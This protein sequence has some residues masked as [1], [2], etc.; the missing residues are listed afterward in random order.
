[1]SLELEDI[2]EKKHSKGMYVIVG[3]LLIGMA[4]FG[5]SQFGTGGG[6]SRQ[7]LLEAGNSVVTKRDYDDALRF[8]QG[9]N[10]NLTAEQSRAMALSMLRQRVALADYLN[11][12]Q[13]A[14]SNRQIDEVIT[15]TP[16]FFDN[17]KFSET[18]FR[19]KVPIAAEQ[20]RRGVSNDIA[21]REF[22]TVLAGSVVV[23]DAELQPYLDLVAMSRDILVAKIARNQFSATAD[24]DEIQAFYDKNKANFMTAEQWDIEYVDFNPE[25]IVAAEKVD[26]AVVAD[27]VVA[28]RHVAYLLFDDAD[29]AQAVYQASQSGKTWDTL[30][31]EFAAE[32]SDSGELGKV[33]KVAD[34]DSLVSQDALD[35]IFALA[36][37]GEMTAPIKTDDG[38]M[39]FTVTHIEK[40]DS[41]SQTAETAKLQ[42]Q[43]A[44]AAGKI[45]TLSEKLNKAVF[46]NASPTLESIS[47]ATELPVSHTGLVAAN[48]GQGILALPEVLEAINQSDKTLGKI[49]EPITVGE[50]VLIYRLKAI[51][52]SEQ[53]PLETVK[54]HVEQGIIAEKV[55]KQLAEASNALVEATKTD[56]LETAA[57]AKNYPVQAYENFNGNVGEGSVL[58]PVAAFL[59]AQQPPALDK[60][61]AQIVALPNG[62]SYVY[63]TT[64]VRLQSDDKAQAAEQAK[65]LKANL[66]NEIGGMELGNFLQTVTEQT[67]VT[68]RSQSVLSQ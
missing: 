65:Q 13:L 18:V 22:Q 60:Q 16:A 67:K 53:K 42:V 59:L 15:T 28:P 19:E 6:N 31:N 54:P 37:V 38:I 33:N 23:S 51:K 58:N 50:R 8:I 49:Q 11:R 66:N 9:N 55:E 14:A 35:R 4:G 1:M 27:H 17:G 44:Q 45:A 20:Y 5:T 3:L 7:A 56:G 40:P 25:A 24:A 41:N 64:D 46:E 10:P 2:R 12:H 43:K 34:K 48:S 32:I 26:T 30:N 21:M 29:K 61:N 52:A 47:T 57:T 68:D 63:V 36:N 39:L 62:D